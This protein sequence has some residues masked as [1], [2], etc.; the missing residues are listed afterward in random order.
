MNTPLQSLLKN[1]IEDFCNTNQI[2]IKQCTKK[3]LC[4]MQY[5]MEFT[6]VNTA[7]DAL[8]PQ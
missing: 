8:S 2:Q 4:T 5:S 3:F 7:R 6:V 1:T